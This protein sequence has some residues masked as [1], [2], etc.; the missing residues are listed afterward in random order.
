M[1]CYISVL[2][3]NRPE[4]VIRARAPRPRAGSVA[5]AGRSADPCSRVVQSS[6]LR[7]WQHARES[8]QRS[9]GS[10]QR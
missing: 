2:R 4:P 7:A 10:T 3:L 5:L 1:R 8:R 9:T 6:I